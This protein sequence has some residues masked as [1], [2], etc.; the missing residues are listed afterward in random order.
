MN[1]PIWEFLT[2]A[3]AEIVEIVLLSLA[4]SG[5]AVILSSM[6]AVPLGAYL[7]LKRFA[8]Q[9]LFLRLTYMLM[10]LP[11]VLAGLLV[12][13]ILSHSGPLG[14][15][16]LLFTPVAMVAAQILLVLPIITGLTASAVAEKER[17]VMET[18]LSLGASGSQ[19][20][21]AVMGEARRGIVA[22]ILAGFG[23]AF[24]EV[25]AVML[26]GGNIRHFTRVLTTSIILQ[27]RQGNFALA[28]TLGF[29]LLL[30]SFVVSSI[31]LGLEEKRTW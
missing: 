22:G 20:V 28:L 27:T 11:P 10:S 26:V 13:L 19:A 15:L 8:G 3:H 29:I 21:L 14:R 1:T 12:Y 18:A 4:V 16:N 9:R 7:A 2:A 17:V 31:M 30:I 23:R 6:V 24:G 25:G 5:S